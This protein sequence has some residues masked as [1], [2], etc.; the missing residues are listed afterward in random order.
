MIAIAQCESGLNP[1][2][3]GPT[4]DGGIFQIHMPSHGERM[5]ALGLDIWNPEDNVKFA[6]MLYDESGITPWV[7]AGPKFLAFKR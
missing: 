2:A 4:Q 3:K 6:R 1:E 5:K 7:C